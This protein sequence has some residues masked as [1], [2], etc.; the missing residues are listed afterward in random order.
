MK[1]L[2]DAINRLA[3][4]HVRRLSEIGSALS[5]LAEAFTHSDDKPLSEARSGIDHL[6]NEISNLSATLHEKLGDLVPPSED[7]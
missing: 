2:A 6:S 4:V 7:D 5:K 1:E 3:E